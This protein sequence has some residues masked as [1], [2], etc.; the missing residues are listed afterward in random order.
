[1]AKDF[2]AEG[3]TEL[4]AKHR[5]RSRHTALT[6]ADRKVYIDTANALEQ[7]AATLKAVTTVLTEPDYTKVYAPN[8][9]RDHEYEHGIDCDSIA[10]SYDGVEGDSGL[11]C[12][13]WIS[14]LQAK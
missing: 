3:L 9:P 6:T 2:T 7:A 11:P 4:A 12:D 13:C 8:E 10:W 14:V 1:M 5:Q